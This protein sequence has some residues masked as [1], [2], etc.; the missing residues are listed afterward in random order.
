MH[1]ER[2]RNVSALL[3]TAAWIVS[4]RAAAGQEPLELAGHAG[5]VNAAQ[6]TPDGQ[7][8]ITVSSDHSAILWDLVRREALQ[9]YEGHQGPIYGMALSGDGRALATGAQDNTLRLWDVPAPRPVQWLAGHE[10]RATRLALGGEGALITVGQDARVRVWTVGRSTPHAVR[11]GHAGEVLSA[12]YRADNLQFA[13]GDAGGVVRLWAPLLTESQAVIGAHAGGATSLAFHPNNQL[14]LSAGADGTWKLW[15]LTTPAPKTFAGHTDAVRAV[16]LANNQPLVVTG[17]VDKSLRVLNMN[18]GQL[19]R[20][21]KGHETGVTAAAVSPNN[22]LLAS[23]DETGRIRFWNFGDGAD[24]LSAAGHAGPV[25]ALAFHPD[26]QRVVSG[27]ADGTLRIWQTPVP[28]QVLG[29]HGGTIRGIAISPNGQWF[30]TVSDDRTARLWNSDGQAVRQFGD[31]GQPVRSVALRA[32]N[33]Q[34]ATGDAAGLVRLWNPNDGAL[35]ATLGAHPAAATHTAYL[36]AGDALYTAGEDGTLK[37]W[38]L[39]TPAP[40]VLSGHGQPV[41]SVALSADA[42]LAVTGSPDQTVR[43]WDTGNGQML[44]ALDQPP[45]PVHAVALSGDGGLVAA[46]GEAGVIKFWNPADGADRLRVIG[47][48]GTIH[49]LAFDP[50]SRLTATAHADGTVRVWRVPAPPRELPG[51][52]RP[53]HVAAT[54]RDGTRLALGGTAGDKPAIIVRNLE[55]GEVT[56]TLLGHE[57]PVTALAFSADGKRLISGSADRTARVWGLSEAGT[58]ELGRFAGHPGGVQSVVLAS[59]GATAWSSG[60]ENAI[61]EWTVADGAEVRKVEGHGGNVVALHVRDQML[62]SGSADGTAR[63]WDAANGGMLRAMNHGAAVTGVAVSS[64]G[65]RIV[66]SGADNTAK[67]WNAGDG[68]LTATLSGSPAAITALAFSLDGQRVAC[69]SNDGARLWQVDGRPLERIET[70][71]VIS[72]GLAFT[73]DGQTLTA[74]LPDGTVRSHVVAAAQVFTGHEGPVLSVTFTGDGAHVVSGGNDKTV[75]VRKLDDDQSVRMLAGPTDVVTDL[76]ASRDG[77]WLAAACGDKSAFLWSLGEVTAAPAGQV[78]PAKRSLVHAAAVRGVSLSAEGQRLATCGDDNIVRLWDTATGR[79]LERFAGHGAAALAVALAIDGRTLISGAA[80]NSARVWGASVMQ[81]IVPERPLAD[82]AVLPDGAL[83][84]GVDGVLPHVQ[85]WNAEGQPARQLI[86]PKAPLLR[87]A[88]RPGGEIFAADGEGRVFAWTAPAGAGADVNSTRTLETGAAVV[89]LRFSADGKQL[90]AAGQQRVR[91]YDADTFR[92]LEE[93]ALPAAVMQFALSAD[94]RSLLASGAEANPWFC[95]RS[96]LRVI[97]AHAGGAAGVVFT[98][99]GQQIVSG[100]ADKA[101]HVWNLEDGQKMRTFAGHAQAVT[102]VAVTQDGARVVAGGADGLVKT[103]NIADGVELSSLPHAKPVRGV[104]PSPDGTR[105]ATCSDDGVVRVWD[106]ATGRELEWFAGHEGPATGVR[107]AADN[108]TLVSAGAD[109]TTRVWSLSA[110][111]VVPAHPGGVL[112]LALL[113]G[114]GQLVTCGSDGR[115]VLWDV[116]SGQLV[117]EFQGHAG[118]VAALAVRNDNQRL[119]AGGADGKVHIWNPGDGSPLAQLQGPPGVAALA[120]SPDNQKLAVSGEQRLMLFGP[121]PM[122]QP[123]REL[124]RHVE[125]TAESRL[126]DVA[127]AADSRRVLATHESGNVS[128][129]AYASPAMVRQFN[130]GGP[131]HGVAIT[132]DGTTV[133]SA[134]A[135]QT[136]RVW[137]ATNGQQRFQLNGH[138][139]AVYAVTLT[140]DAVLAL[141]AGADNTLRLWDILGGRQLKQLPAGDATVYSITIDPQGKTFAAAGADRKIRVYDLGTGDLQRTIEGHADY[142]HGLAFNPAGNRLLSYGYAGH[143]K[144]WNPADGAPVY[145]TKV[146]EVGN[147]AAWS[148]DG[149]RVV[150]ANGDGVARVVTLPEGA[151]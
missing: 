79:E 115:V 78:V 67:V 35:Q 4:L 81:L 142:I 69:A 150:L 108:R 122:P 5:A 31:H 77:A 83:V 38:Q 98:P 143:L 71:N 32:D 26:S 138:Q 37:R 10:G 66:S 94:G 100:G 57:G 104:S 149:T 25:S 91:I 58:P 56:A 88:V 72:G 134:S 85:L 65:A 49:D 15:Q 97:D 89:G 117:R 60:G 141:S 2:R 36:P 24:R 34:M 137:D 102:C 124:E 44:R 106:A 21:I 63:V 111:R 133:V 40:R 136:V 90:A 128:E 43:L 86:G 74:C 42:K 13:T 84:A 101:V 116:G 145:A 112:D 146:G 46:A 30:A 110:V 93:V 121:P 33:A 19:V 140:S 75:R 103:W 18:D 129:W 96:L 41:R 109:K 82:L 39:S 118:N 48:G 139:G 54:S 28:P 62:I 130:H 147:A 59:D 76:A 47:L 45:G 17:G 61:H 22:G 53:A 6:F 113:A 99:N 135:D 1:R 107:F 68:Q 51:E 126:T 7:R 127:F 114:G 64:A 20:E 29:G 80:D 55:T 119:A 11:T 12:A 27:G 3:I 9:K 8:I 16:A 132:H 14:L 23:A 131:V 70:G 105:L 52:K 123:A 50:R 120:Y 148:P 95:R 92:L 73:G 144:V 151:R 125:F 87:L